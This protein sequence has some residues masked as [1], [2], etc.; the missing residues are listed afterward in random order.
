[1]T[2]VA[3]TRRSD[4]LPLAT[5][6]LAFGVFCVGTSEFML[7]GLLPEIATDL[8]ISIPAAGNL[9]TAFAVGMLIGAPV[10]ALLTIRLP[11]KATLLGA[12]GIFG[13]AHLIPLLI[14][15]Y[16]A[17]LISRVVAAV[18]CAGYWAVS[19]VVAASIAP[20]D[21]LARSM[22]AI[23]GGLTISN[24]LGVPIGTW[25]GQ[26]FGWQS[27]FL[28]VAVAAVVTA[29][30]VVTFVRIPAADRSDVSMT[31][32]VRTEIRVFADRRVWLALATTALFQ[33]AVFCTF[34]YL[35]VLL[36]ERSGISEGLVP[37]VLLLFGLGAFAGVTIGG[38]YGDRN[39][40]LNVVVSLIA[41][42]AS[43]LLLILVSG[44]AV[45]AVITVVLLGVSAFSIAASIN[46]RVL[47]FAG[48]APTLAAAVNVS[49]FNVGNALGPWLGGLVI[50][51]GLGVV[52]PTWVAVGLALGALAVVAVSARV[53]RATPARDVGPSTESPDVRTDADL[54]GECSTS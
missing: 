54:V 41:I 23:V 34:S 22:A 44:S 9:I 33:G 18:A 25:L 45:G 1:M 20:P 27:A 49:A 31:S 37:V 28:A 38:R 53:E 13:V 8:D 17:T 47:G 39:M 24:V 52:A 30:L 19:A 36:T 14:P 2:T 51:A 6:V 7:A 10:T 21:R 15:T 32:L 4:R 16:E 35:A 48:D 26:T 5:Y 11:R 50:A 46:G 42:V 3:E 40:L 29:A 43:L 12:I